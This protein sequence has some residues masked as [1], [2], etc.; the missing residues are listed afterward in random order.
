LAIIVLGLVETTG[1]VIQIH[2]PDPGPMLPAGI[3]Q[4]IITWQAVRVRADVGR[5]LDVVMTTADVGAATGNADVAQ[6]Q[7]QA[8]VGAHVVVGEGVLGAAH[9]P[10]EGTGPILGH[11]LGDLVAAVTPDPGDA[12]DFV[13]RPFGDFL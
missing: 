8:V 10:D 13:R 3:G 1:Q 11:G 2:V 4:W 6:R 12:L 9:A 5:A 7:L